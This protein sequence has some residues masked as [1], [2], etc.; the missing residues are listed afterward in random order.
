MLR[1]LLNIIRSEHNQ[2]DLPASD[3]QY[4]RTDIDYGSLSSSLTRNMEKIKTAFGKSSDLYERKITTAG[5]YKITLFFIDG[6]VNETDIS[7]FLIN[8]LLK[9]TEQPRNDQSIEFFSKQMIPS[10][11]VIVSH[12][13]K[14]VY[15]NLL[16]GFVIV[17]F[18]G[19]KKAYALNFSGGEKRSLEDSKLEK[20]LRGPRDAFVEDLRT[21]TSL[22]RRR[23]KNL[24]LQIENMTL[25]SRSGTGVCIAYLRDIANLKIVE[26]LQNRLL[27]INFDNIQDSTYIAHLIED[28]PFSIFPL[29]L[30]TEKPDKV[31]SNLLEG[32]IVLLSD[33][34]PTAVLIPTVFGDYF[35]IQD[36][37]YDYFY[38][39]SI[40]RMIR[41]LG[42]F[43]ATL[44][45]PLYI[46]LTA[47]NL[48]MLP[49]K[50]ALPFSQIR[51]VIPFPLVV[52]VIIMEITLELLREAGLRIPSPIGPAISIVGGLVIGQTAVNAGF[53]SPF[54]TIVVAL[55]AIG[56]FAIP[57][58]DLVSTFRIVKGLLIIFSSL[59]GIFGIGAVITILIIH[60]CSLTCFGIPY[61]APFSEKGILI[62]IKDVL[63]IPF[64]L[65]KKRHSYYRI[66][67]ESKV[68]SHE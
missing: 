24:N 49:V 22:I 31:A 25:G 65:S 66:Q 40:S 35:H 27:Q 39:A 37:Y 32:K 1:D 42:A 36:D 68:N 10:T 6:L 58:A 21:N 14:D 12:T 8:S 5:N 4:D 26:E 34:S 62:S 9:S 56:S 33:N 19:S 52:E 67:D 50:L 53:T 41:I 3:I 7:A 30:K 38:I 46:A 28:N 17:L 20:N 54:L 64:K 48:D 51:Y 60:M 43:L 55:S 13:F 44:A 47:I 63:R 23:I 16:D 11:N 61:L 57:Y 15:L 18:E 45:T 29:L 2:K 59:F